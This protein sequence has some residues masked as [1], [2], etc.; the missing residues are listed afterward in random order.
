MLFV[1]KGTDS[2]YQKPI[3][4]SIVTLPLLEPGEYGMRIIKDAN[5]NGKW[6]EGAVFRN[7]QPEH[8]IPYSGKLMLKAGWDS[9]V[10]FWS[11]QL[12]EKRARMSGR[13]QRRAKR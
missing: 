9:E 8:V 3:T 4:D 2:I 6:D 5:K 7:I 1:Y 12:P 10:D 11:P 13:E